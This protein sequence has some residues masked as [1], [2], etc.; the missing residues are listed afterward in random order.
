MLHMVD[1]GPCFDATSVMDCPSKLNVRSNA[2]GWNTAVRPSAKVRCAAF[3]VVGALAFPLLTMKVP[4]PRDPQSNVPIKPVLAFTGEADA[5]ELPMT[6]IAAPRAAVP[7]M[8]TAN[9]W[10]HRVGLLIVIPPI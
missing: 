10:T 9:R 6:T 8:Q 7:A 1:P 2:L 5:P 3:Q 4:A